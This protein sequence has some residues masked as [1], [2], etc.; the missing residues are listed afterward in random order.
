MEGQGLHHCLVW[1]GCKWAVRTS[2]APPQPRPLLPGVHTVTEEA[3]PLHD[4]SNAKSL[5]ETIFLL[6]S[7]N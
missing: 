7:L 4:I 2:P 6:G 5:R 3:E 1:C